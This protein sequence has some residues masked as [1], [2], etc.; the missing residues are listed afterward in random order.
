MPRSQKQ[1]ELIA[2][3]H[4]E[5]LFRAANFIGSRANSRPVI[6]PASVLVPDPTG[7]LAALIQQLE[8]P[9]E[10][11]AAPGVPSD[12]AAARAR[13]NIE[14]WMSYLPIDCVRTMVHAG[15]QWTT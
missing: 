14:A 13:D 11:A 2:A 3:L 4:L 8:L 6:V 9:V 15:W 12:A 1:A 10:M 5:P 7:R